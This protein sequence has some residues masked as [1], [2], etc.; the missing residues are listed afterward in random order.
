MAIEWREGA[1]CLGR[2]ASDVSALSGGVAKSRQTLH[3]FPSPPLKFRTV[4]FPQYGFKP[5][6]SR[7]DLR[8]RPDALSDRPASGAGPHSYTQPPALGCTP[9]AHSGKLGRGHP[10]ER[11]QSRGPWLPTRLC[12]PPGSSLTTASCAPLDS[13]GRFMNYATGPGP[14]VCSG[15]EPRGSPIYSVCLYPPCRLPYPDG[16]DG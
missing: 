5:A 6:I 16:L 15:L 1:S 3:T 11:R 2:A 14:T 10:P 13:A 4:G 12:C 7:C 9:V 8:L